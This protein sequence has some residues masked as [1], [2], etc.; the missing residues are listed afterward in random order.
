MPVLHGA[1]LNGLVP[2][3]IHSGAKVSPAS[4]EAQYFTSPVTY[5]VTAAD[6]F[7][8]VYTVTV[9]RKAR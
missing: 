2:I 6:E 4:G 1:S 7:T 3:I 8:A 9:H 5:T